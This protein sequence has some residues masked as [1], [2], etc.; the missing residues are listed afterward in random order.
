[1]EISEEILLESTQTSINFIKSQI[2]DI[3]SRIKN[4]IDIDPDLKSKSKLLQ[5]IPGIGDATAAQVLAFISK[6]QTFK[7]AKQMAA[8]IGLNP[9]HRVSVSSVRGKTHL[10][11]MAC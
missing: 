7:S 8:F 2:K 1:M 5:T 10:L 3:K 9:K 4:H 11:F 6:T